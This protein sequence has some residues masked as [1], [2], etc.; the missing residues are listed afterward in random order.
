MESADWDRLRADQQVLRQAVGVDLPFGRFE[1]IGTL[2]FA[3]WGLL[4]AI[5]TTFAPSEPRWLLLGPV[6]LLIPMLL[7]TVFISYKRRSVAPS[8]WR[9]YR[10]SLI[11]GGVFFLASLADKAWA[12]AV[13]RAVI[14]P[15]EGAV[16]VIGLGVTI[17]AVAQRNRLSYLGIGLPIMALGLVLPWCETMPQK[18]TG[19]GMTIFYGSLL[20]A[21]LQA[22]RLRRERAEKTN[23][24]VA[25]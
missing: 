20:T 5:W 13:D 9:E 24:H 23:V 10:Y 17:T 11:A 22:L 3:A 7:V 8:A 15:Q 19:I 16:F 4:L 6:W 2:V 1:V 25:D 18:L 21:A 12:A 14:L